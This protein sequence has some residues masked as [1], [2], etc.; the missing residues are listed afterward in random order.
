VESLVGAH[1]HHRAP[2]APSVTMVSSARQQAGACAA[3]ISQSTITRAI[4]LPCFLSFLETVGVFQR[5][6]R[7]ARWG[8]FGQTHH[9]SL[10]TL[11]CLMT[12]PD[13]PTSVSFLLLSLFFKKNMLGRRLG[14]LRFV[15]ALCYVLTWA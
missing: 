11:R 2:P 14:A 7:S 4:L 9:D 1:H 8:S 10:S 6:A 5:C 13:G 15:I 3:G 12:E